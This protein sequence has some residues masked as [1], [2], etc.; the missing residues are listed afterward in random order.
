MVLVLVLVLDLEAA[1]IGT[2]RVLVFS[3]G[4]GLGCCW[5]I[6]RFRRYELLCLDAPPDLVGSG[7]HP[8]FNR[9]FH[10]KARF[11]ESFSCCETQ[12]RHL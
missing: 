12:V 5:L 6:N 9:T 4:I 7:G 3:V 10:Q 1:Q 2:T 11:R 8:P